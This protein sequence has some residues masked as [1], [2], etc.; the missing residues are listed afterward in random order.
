MCLVALE[1]ISSS[2]LTAETPLH[3]GLGSITGVTVFSKSRGWVM[4]ES[5]LFPQHSQCHQS[6]TMVG[7]HTKILSKGALYQVSLSKERKENSVRVCRMCLVKSH[8]ACHSKTRKI[9][10]GFVCWLIAHTT[11]G[12]QLIFYSVWFTLLMYVN[13]VWRRWILH[14]QCELYSTL[15]LLHHN[16]EIKWGVS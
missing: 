16:W 2:H 6:C 12:C 1:T 13:T 14:K 7:G 8:A 9:C 15:Q 3:G 4:C 11:S 5:L 10:R